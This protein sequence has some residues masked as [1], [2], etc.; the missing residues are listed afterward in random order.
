MKKIEFFEEHKKN[1]NKWNCSKK[2]KYYVYPSMD[3]CGCIVLDKLTDLQALDLM[4]E[5]RK[6][7]KSL[8]KNN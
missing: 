2:C 4:G 6:W 8:S 1:S 5:Y 3:S 7:E